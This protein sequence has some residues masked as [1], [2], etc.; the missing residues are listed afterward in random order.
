ME[1]G[2]LAWRSSRGQQ[3]PNVEMAD[4]FEG[5]VREMKPDDKGEIR[6]LDTWEHG[7]SPK[8]EEAE[9]IVT[10]FVGRLTLQGSHYVVLT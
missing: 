4:R 1:G 10:S 6:A 9:N 2:H 8:L 3:G 5:N 7:V